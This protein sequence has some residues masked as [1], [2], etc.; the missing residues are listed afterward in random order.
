MNKRMALALLVAA[1]LLAGSPGPAPAEEKTPEEAGEKVSFPATYVRVAYN[2]EA[3]VSMGFRL[4]NESVGEDWMLLQAAMTVLGKGKE[5]RYD[6][7]RKDITLVIPGPKE[8][9]LATQQEFGEAGS[10]IALNKR[11]DVAKDNINYFPPQTSRACPLSF[12]TGPIPGAPRL[13][14]EKTELNESRACGG[15]LF[16]KIPG[17]VQ[18]GTYN[19]NVKFKNSTIRVPFKIMT[20]DEVKQ[21]EKELKELRKMEKEKKKS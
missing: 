14:R 21:L 10:L 16:F 15:R 19:L 17:G 9:P 11:A 4:A 1:A 13:A 7:D 3:W 18:L 12:F 6:I 2:E 8:I 5:A 20:K